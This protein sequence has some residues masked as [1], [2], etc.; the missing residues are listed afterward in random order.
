[1]RGREVERQ[2][3]GLSVLINAALYLAACVAAAL[4]FDN[5][6]AWVFA[7]ASAGAAYLG[8]AAQWASAPWR[9]T[10]FVVGASVAFALFSGLSIIVGW[11]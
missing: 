6:S 2:L 7:A 10:A 3:I 4:V 5:R 8:Y 1:M 11:R 9:V